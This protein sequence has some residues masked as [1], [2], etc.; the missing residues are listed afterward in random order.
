MAKK[1]SKRPSKPATGKAGRPAKKPVPKKKTKKQLRSEAAK[2]GWETRKRVAAEAEKKKK[3]RSL[4]SK[5][6]W[7]TR[8]QKSAKV[9]LPIVGPKDTIE[10]FTNPQ[11]AADYFKKTFRYNFTRDGKKFYEREVEKFETRTKKIIRGAIEDKRKELKGKTSLELFDEMMFKFPDEL[12]TKYL[13]ASDATLRKALLAHEKSLQLQAGAILRTRRDMAERVMKDVKKASP[14]DTDFEM[15]HRMDK[16]TRM[17]ASFGASEVDVVPGLLA[18][19]IGAG[20]YA[21]RDALALQ[22]KDE[23]GWDL[24]LIYKMIH[25]PGAEDFELAN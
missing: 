21:T 2:K 7:E 23:T 14:Y 25:S 9:S 1:T 10:G 20:D 4:A 19:A 22:I 16:M 24:R 17:L 3:A 8:R 6:G 5:K 13:R 12:K 15:S 11:D 18:S